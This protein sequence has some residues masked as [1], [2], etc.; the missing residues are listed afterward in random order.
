MNS[1]KEKNSGFFHAQDQS[2]RAVIIEW[3]KAG[4]L[5]L[6][7]ANFK[8]QVSDLAS[9][10]TASS[11]T[12]FLQVHPEAVSSGGFLKA[13][14]P[15]F[16]QGVELVDWGK[17]EETLQASIKQFYTVDISLFGAEVINK[18]IDDVYFFASIKDKK[19]EKLLGFLMAS[20][21]P[22]L[23]AGDIKLIN[24]IVEPAQQHSGLQQL[25]LASLIKVLPQVKR[26][27]TMVRPVNNEA[28]DVFAECGFVQ[29]YNPIQDPNH[30]ID[31]NHLIV[32]EYK[33]E[34][35]DLLQDVTDQL[36]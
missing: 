30:P 5:A 2:G 21:T 23:P 6:E 26:I 34:Q 20:I 10:V 24:L 29:D 4:I 33:M 35:S 25:L 36:N 16:A 31:Q 28:Q 11:E 15:L 19:T 18:L 32:L 3:H 12:Q 1:Y 13:C 27:F 7:L 17:V 8:K 9:Q 22:A 14:E